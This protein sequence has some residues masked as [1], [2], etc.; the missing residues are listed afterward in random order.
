MLSRGGLLE[1]WDGYD[2]SKRPEGLKW[3][4]KRNLVISSTA[5][6]APITY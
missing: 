2:A 6:A 1:H 5:Q 4:L 3:G